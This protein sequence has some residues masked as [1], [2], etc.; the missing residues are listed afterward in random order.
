MESNNTALKTRA[1][2]LT[3]HDPLKWR[4]E[5]TGGNRPALLPYGIDALLSRGYQFYVPRVS[6]R[7]LASRLRTVVEHRLGYPVGR[8]LRSVGT[9]ARADVVI[10]LLEQQG[11]AAA[12]A[13]RWRVAPFGKT[14][15]V[16]WSCWLADELMHL[17]REERLLR[18]RDYS[19]ADLLIHFSEQETDVLVGSGFRTEQ[20]LAMPYAIESRYYAPTT[21]PRDLDLVAIGQDRGRDY[22]TLLNAVRGTSLRLDIVCKPENL[23][24]L[25]I[26]PNVTVHR[27]VDHEEYRELLRRAKVVVVPT[28]EMMYPTGSSVALEGASSGACVVVSRTIPMETYFTDRKNALFVDVG[29]VEAMRRILTEALADEGLRGR[30][31]VEGRALVETRFDSARMW[32][33]V[34]DALRERGIL[35]SS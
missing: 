22:A 10:A 31:G 20:L 9:T 4:R 17:P 34:D 13:K 16:I 29:D 24:G 27:T 6:D 8:L 30:L 23:R 5:Y 35:G 14:P 1:V 21:T 7:A 26:P 3:E 12:K 28:V 15:L 11:L 33:K 32:V 2:L 19:S 25:D 18:A